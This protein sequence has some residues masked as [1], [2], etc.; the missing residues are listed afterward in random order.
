[1]D[2]PFKLP[3]PTI[4]HKTMAVHGSPRSTGG[5]LLHAGVLLIP[6]R[7]YKFAATAAAAAAEAAARRQ[8]RWKRRRRRRCR[9]HRRHRRHCLR[10]RRSRRR[11]HLRWHF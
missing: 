6:Q 7:R 10:C 2:D 8:W 11:C 9:R 1:M 5:V 3:L 4:P